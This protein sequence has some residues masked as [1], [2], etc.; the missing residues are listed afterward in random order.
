MCWMWGSFNTINQKNRLQIMLYA[1]HY[2]EIQDFIYNQ[3]QNLSQYVV[4][5]GS[6]QT[7]ASTSRLPESKSASAAFTKPSL[8]SIL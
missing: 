5:T 6:S 2:L 1:L 8:Y 7:I 4:G 3:A